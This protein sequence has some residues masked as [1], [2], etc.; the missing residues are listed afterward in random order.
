MCVECWGSIPTRILAA[1]CSCQLQ[2]NTMIQT[3]CYPSS[4][5][6]IGL[7]FNV[8]MFSCNELFI[9]SIYIRIIE[10]SSWYELDYSFQARPSGHLLQHSSKYLILRKSFE[11]VFRTFSFCIVTG[12]PVF[13]FQ[14]QG[15]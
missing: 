6:C 1:A 15:G 14:G 13:G 11:F 9:L 2:N 10:L 7:C 5:L 8:K 4:L 3:R 12:T